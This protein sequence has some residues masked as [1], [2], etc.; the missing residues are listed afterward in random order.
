MLQPLLFDTNVNSASRA[1]VGNPGEF[2]ATYQSYITAVLDA[3]AAA[4]IKCFLDLHNY[5]RYRDFRYQS[6]V[7]VIGLTKAAEPSIYPYTT[8]PNQVYTRIFATAPGA[9]LTV[10]HFTDFWTRA[11]QNWKDHPG[12]G[13]YGLINE[14][15]NLP[16]PGG[17]TETTNGDEDQLLWPPFAK[18][19]IAALR[20]IDPAGLIYLDSNQWSA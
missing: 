6:N 20:A 2:N 17:T 12:F 14:P 4:G 7:S 18:A 15:Y 13:G 1:V 19:A 9:T 5:C 3:H 8:D 10:Q 11:A 16:A